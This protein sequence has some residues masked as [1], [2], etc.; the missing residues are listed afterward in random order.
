LPIE[1]R[2]VPI[3]ENIIAEAIKLAEKTGLPLRDFI[4]RILE[5]VIN[6][7]KYRPDLLELIQ[8][9]DVIED[10]RRIGGVILPYN[11]VYEILN[12][13]DEEHYNKIVD[14]V[15]KMASWY[16]LVVKA[17]FATDINVLKRTLHIWL[18]DM[19]IDISRIDN[20]RF[21]IVATSP[22][23]PER[24]TMLAK[25]IAESLIA[26]MDL[27]LESINGSKGILSMVIN[28]AA[29]T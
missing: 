6:Y 27:K 3:N 12:K 4:E 29:K 24:V 11:I 1:K 8:D 5:T 15:K 10:I 13:I 14:E 20:T 21:R 18:P 17:K 2:F 25:E 7:L 9:L 19:K 28:T 23:Q 26:S 16:G 22:N